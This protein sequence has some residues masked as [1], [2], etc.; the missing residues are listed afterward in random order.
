MSPSPRS[1]GKEGRLPMERD[2]LRYAVALFAAATACG[3]ALGP[4]AAV[5]WLVLAIF[6]PVLLSR[7][8]A[9]GPGGPAMRFASGRKGCPRLRGVGHAHSGQYLPEYLRRAR[10]PH[11]GWRPHPVDPLLERQLPHGAQGGG[12]GGQRA[13]HAGDRAAGWRNACG[14]QS[15][16]GPDRGAGSCAGRGK[17]DT[18][19]MGER[20]GLIKFG[21]R[22]DILLGPE[23]EIAV[24]RGDRVAGGSSVLARRK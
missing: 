8:R 24:R 5:P 7:S 15:D 22:V 9:G 21:S 16:R 4:W 20:F 23:W 17:A 6:L 19:E 12:V 3:L 10:Q 11:S 1:P 13:E 14:G 2:G 18:V